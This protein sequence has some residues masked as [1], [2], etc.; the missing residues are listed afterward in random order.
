MNTQGTEIEAPDSR[1]FDRPQL[2]RDWGEFHQTDRPPGARG[3]YPEARKAKRLTGRNSPK[4]GPNSA[5]LGVPLDPVAP[6]LMPL[7]L[8]P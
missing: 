2:P 7:S 6:Y 1:N 5:K 3:T 4:T 8:S